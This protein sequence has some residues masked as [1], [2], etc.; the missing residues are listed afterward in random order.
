VSLPTPESQRQ[1]R[2]KFFVLKTK[3]G[4]QKIEGKIPC[5]LGATFRLAPALIDIK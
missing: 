4:R 3:K 5:P 2:Q 1:K